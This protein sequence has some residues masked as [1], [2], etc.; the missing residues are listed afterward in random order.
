VINAVPENL[1]R[2]IN[3]EEN[4]IDNLMGDIESVEENLQPDTLSEP[5][6]IIELPENICV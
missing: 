5:T 1:V 3:M 2:N 4:M 6:D